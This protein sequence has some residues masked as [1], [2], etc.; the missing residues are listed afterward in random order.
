MHPAVANVGS[1]RCLVPDSLSS[2][3]SSPVTALVPFFVS[4][5]GRLGQN[6]CHFCAIRT[7]FP[8]IRVSIPSRKSLIRRYDAARIPVTARTDLAPLHTAACNGANSGRLASILVNFCQK[9]HNLLFL[10]IYL[11]S[12]RTRLLSSWA[13]AGFQFQP[14]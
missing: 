12:R 5:F 9:D 2:C 3:L 14:R 7:G 13:F 6:S 10:K 11:F 1:Y 4:L 8:S